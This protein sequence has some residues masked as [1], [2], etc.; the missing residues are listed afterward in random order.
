MSIA[1]SIWIPWIPARDGEPDETCQGYEINQVPDLEPASPQRTRFTVSTRL[2]STPEDFHALTNKKLARSA[3][4]F[5]TES[6]KRVKRDA[7]SEPRATNSVLDS[8][9]PYSTP[10][11]CIERKS[12]TCPDA[13]YKARTRSIFNLNQT[14]PTVTSIQH[15]R[16]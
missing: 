12:P 13:P 11:A 15:P 16:W 3:S 14:S 5:R 1:G 8:F 7:R 6:L 9:T 4:P 10:P 2:P